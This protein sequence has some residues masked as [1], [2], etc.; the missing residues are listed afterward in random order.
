MRVWRHTSIP[1]HLS[2]EELARVLEICRRLPAEWRLRNTCMVLIMARLGMRAG[3]VRQLGL[4]DIHWIAGVIHVRRGKSRSERT[5]PLLE[6]VGRVLG[7]YL[8]Q[9]R[10]VTANSRP[11]PGRS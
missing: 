2:T 5:L 6:D 1:Q 10:P 8:Q 4:D 9:E 3:E 11:K 7:T